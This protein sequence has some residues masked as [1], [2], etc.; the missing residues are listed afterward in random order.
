MSDDRVFTKCAWRLIPF[1]M[2]LYFVN[3]VDRV[4]VGFAALTMSKVWGGPGAK[5]SPLPLLIVSGGN[6]LPR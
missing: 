6:I 5:Y 3:C 4:N 1:M 2:L